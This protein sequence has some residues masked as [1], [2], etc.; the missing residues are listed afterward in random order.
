MWN[1]ED[2]FWESPVRDFGS[3]AQRFGASWKKG[4]R[5]SLGKKKW[6][7]LEKFGCV[8]ILGWWSFGG[9]RKRLLCTEKPLYFKKQGREH[10]AVWGRIIGN[11]FWDRS[12]V[13]G[14]T[15]SVYIWLRVLYSRDSKGILGFWGS[16]TQHRRPPPVSTTLLHHHGRL[17]DLH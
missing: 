11:G 12:M 7:F 17:H 6:E 16:R 8:L 3:E 9:A 14:W 2:G 4:E 5:G 15:L 1:R 10:S 13:Q